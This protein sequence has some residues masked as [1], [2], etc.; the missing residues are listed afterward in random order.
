[1]WCNRL[2]VEWG[3]RRE[4]EGKN[5]GWEGGEGPRDRKVRQRSE[6]QGWRMLEVAAEVRDNGVVRGDNKVRGADK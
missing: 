5:G 1:M 3:K 4:Y 6:S 2:L